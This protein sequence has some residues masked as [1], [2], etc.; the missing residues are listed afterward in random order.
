M[1]DGEQRD[2]KRKVALWL[3]S[4]VAA[5]LLLLLVARF[6]RI[7]LWPD[8]LVLPSPWLFVA[9]CAM[10]IPYTLTRA[11]RLRFVL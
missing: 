3:A 4:I 11:L 5:L 10:Q 8:P 1:T 7:D 2:G 9:A 6:G